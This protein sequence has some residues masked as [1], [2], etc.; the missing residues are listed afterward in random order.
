M[1]TY[2][3][4]QRFPGQF[5]VP[6]SGGSLEIGND[7]CY[8]YSNKYPLVPPSGG[9]LEI[10]NDWPVRVRCPGNEVPPSGGS[11]EIGN[12][13]FSRTGSVGQL[14]GVPPSGGSLEI[15]NSLTVIIESVRP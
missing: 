12:N 5:G 7:W 13:P 14:V 4:T 8:T 15:G 6:P 11:L 9:S 10:G 2:Q 1:E 3:G